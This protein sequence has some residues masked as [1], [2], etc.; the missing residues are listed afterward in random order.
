MDRPEEPDGREAAIDVAAGHDMNDASAEEMGALLQTSADIV[1]SIPS[2][3]FIC[4]Y[5]P[6]D[7][8]LLTGSNP[9]AETLTGISAAKYGGRKVDELMPEARRSGLYAELIRVMQTGQ[10]YRNDNFFYKDNRFDVVLRIRAFRIPRHCL[11]V[12]FEDV[13]ER[14]RAYEIL[15]ASE[16]RYRFLFRHTPVMMHSI[17]NTGTIVNVSDHWLKT[18]GYTRDEVI[19]RKLTA[20]FTPESRR[21]A[22]ETVLPAFFVSGVC[23]SVHYQVVKKSGETIDVLLSA[24]AERSPD[25]AFQR[26]LAVITDV[27][28]L[29]RAENEARRFT[30]AVEQSNSAILIANPDGIIEYVNPSYTRVTGRTDADVVGRHFLSIPVTRSTRQMYQRAWDTAKEHG[31]WNGIFQGKT[32]T[33]HRYITRMVI[34]PVV[35]PAGRVLDYV[36]K[37][38]DITAEILLHRRMAEAEKQSAVG[39]LAAGVAHEFKNYLCGIIG[40]ATFSLEEPDGPATCREMRRVLGMIV[41]IA[42]RANHLATSLLSYSKAPTDK[43]HP[44]DLAAI[45]T[46]TLVLV[47]TELRKSSIEVITHF[48]DIGAVNVAPGGIQQILLNLLINARQ[49]IASH[50]VIM[51]SLSRYGRVVFLTVADSGGGIPAEIRS[52][53]FD[54]FF[55]TK[56]VWGGDEPGG[57]G[58]GLS[59][60]RNIAEDHGGV[61]TVDSLTGIGTIFTLALPIDGPDTAGAGDGMDGNGFRRI[62]LCTRNTDLIRRYLPEVTNQHCRLFW[63]ESPAGKETAGNAADLLLWDD[64][65]ETNIPADQGMIDIPV[66]VIR[67]RSDRIAGRPVAAFFEDAPSLATIFE[68]VA[69]PSGSSD[70]AT[71]EIREAD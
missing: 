12:A 15:H 7:G 55:S 9:E 68:A 63:I 51:I 3:L 65:S 52:R 23:H 6:P 58:L 43:P 53:V 61:L 66:A 8:L 33:G 38:D 70:V 19:G 41:D 28:P 31:F 20:F 67:G 1:A 54:P 5:E 34:T 36:V 56:G 17:D 47:E 18:M 10:P 11:G 60:C 48:E 45:V 13:T 22:E 49:A 37:A 16:K 62:I 50:G 64:D 46:Q 2:G 44:Q 24:T 25:G 30:R 4:R 69:A 26:S 42:E 40:N 27:T 32:K 14:T 39:L 21:F 57:S 35:D 59:V 29:K 71:A